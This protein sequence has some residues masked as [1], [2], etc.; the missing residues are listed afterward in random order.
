MK[1][2]HLASMSRFDRNKVGLQVVKSLAKLVGQKSE[3]NLYICHM[4]TNL[5]IGN[6]QA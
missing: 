1:Q 4:V 3:L 6:K 2:K 5:S